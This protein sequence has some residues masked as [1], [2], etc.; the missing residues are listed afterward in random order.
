MQPIRLLGQH[1]GEPAKQNLLMLHP[2]TSLCLF[3]FPSHGLIQSKQGHIPQGFP[4]WRLLFNHTVGFSGWALRAGRCR[5]RGGWQGRKLGLVKSVPQGWLYLA[6]IKKPTSPVAPSQ[7][8]CYHNLI[9]TAY[10]PLYGQ[11]NPQQKTKSSGEEFPYLPNNLAQKASISHLRPN[12]AFPQRIRSLCLPRAAAG[13]W[14]DH[15]IDS[16]PFPLLFC[17]A[18]QLPLSQ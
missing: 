2:L 11:K 4:V 14:I 1:V 13:P 15:Q 9:F 16:S 10:E 8:L 6:Q 12:L 3:I 7:S 5:G 18:S 17:E